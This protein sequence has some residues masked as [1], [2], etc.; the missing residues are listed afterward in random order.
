VKPRRGGGKPPAK[1]ARSGG[2]AVIA[3]AVMGGLVVLYG[4]NSVFLAPKGQ[5]KAKART[6]LAAA[7]QQEEQLRRNLADLR[8]LAG[9]GQAREAELVRLAR[10][11]PADPDVPG[12][13]DTLNETARQAQVAF[14]S[15]VP[16]PPS[17][18]TGGSTALSI[19]MKVSGT[20]E[21]I[22]DYLRR[23]ELLDR[24]VVVDSLQLNASGESAGSPVLDA[25]VQA[26]MFSAGAAT[27]AAGKTAAG[28]TA[29]PSDSSALPKA[30]G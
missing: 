21:Q 10:L 3:L 4:W 30:G 28:A 22:F 11:I 26:R 9:D 8:K 16:S 23:L 19:N 18:T 27:P 29:S 7:R 5:A 25:N 6:E 17:P 1:A 24:L 12:A 15:F 14:S 2:K 20:F 13:I